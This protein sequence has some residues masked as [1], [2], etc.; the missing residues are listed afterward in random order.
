MF[1]KIAACLVAAIAATAMIYFF[2]LPRL[3]PPEP[4]KAELLRLLDKSRGRSPEARVNVYCEDR[5]NNLCNKLRSES[6]YR[7][8]WLKAMD[9]L[10]DTKAAISRSEVAIEKQL[11]K[12]KADYKRM[13]D[14][15]FK[16]KDGRAVFGSQNGG[17]KWITEDNQLVPLNVVIDSLGECVAVHYP[18]QKAAN[19][20]LATKR[21][22]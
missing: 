17:G 1:K 14:N 8:K 20:C 3:N 21:G 19:E 18:N 11:A 9:K 2:V 16:L 13:I 4:D 22:K 10:A 5:S 15:A 12:A 7:D 6:A